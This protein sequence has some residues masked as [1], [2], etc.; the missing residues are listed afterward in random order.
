MG[1]KCILRRLAGGWGWAVNIM[2]DKKHSNVT[3]CVEEVLLPKFRSRH[4]CSIS[5]YLRL[6]KVLFNRLDNLRLPFRQHIERHCGLPRVQA[7]GILSWSV[8]CRLAISDRWQSSLRHVS[9]VSTAQV[10]CRRVSYVKKLAECARHYTFRIRIKVLGPLVNVAAWIIS[11]GLSIYGPFMFSSISSDFGSLPQ[12]LGHT[13][14][15]L[16]ELYTQPIVTF[17]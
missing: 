2:C 6:N 11:L 15:A 12:K 3:S 13:V 4:L 10:K 14:V 9:C 5:A 16:S 7:V 8:L 1:S 17:I